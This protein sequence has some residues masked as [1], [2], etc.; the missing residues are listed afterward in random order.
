M[1]SANA[2]RH[3]YLKLI[4]G[5]LTP[6]TLAAVIADLDDIRE[7][8]LVPWTRR[9]LADHLVQLTGEKY[10]AEAMIDAARQANGTGPSEADITEGIALVKK[11]FEQTV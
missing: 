2:T 11:R 6:S 1:P 8:P 9:L 4:A 3:E 7:T 10:R 5:C